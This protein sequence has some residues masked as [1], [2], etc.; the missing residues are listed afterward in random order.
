MQD[1]PVAPVTGASKRIGLQIAKDL[2]MDI[3]RLYYDRHG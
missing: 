2:G 3:L 1:K